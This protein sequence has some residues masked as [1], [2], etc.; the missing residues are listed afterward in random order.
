MEQLLQRDG[1]GVGAPVLPLFPSRAP[2]LALEAGL[3]RARVHAPWPPAAMS[4]G[5]FRAQGGSAGLLFLLDLESTTLNWRTN[6]LLRITD[7]TSDN[8]SE[9][10]SLLGLF[11]KVHFREKTI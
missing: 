10:T 11:V 3:R 2:R 1:R 9:N 7:R 6:R 5:G 8:G 4:A